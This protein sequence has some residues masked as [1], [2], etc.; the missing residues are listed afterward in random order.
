M[1]IFDTS[2][3][4][5]LTGRAIGRSV[6][7]IAVLIAAIGGTAT[8][9]QSQVLSAAPAS[10]QAADLDLGQVLQEALAGQDAALSSQ[11]MTGIE[12]AVS[13]WGDEFLYALFKGST[14]LD[15][16]AAMGVPAPPSN[17][18]VETQAEL[19][20][21]LEMQRSDRTPVELTHIAIE[22]L[23]GMFPSDLYEIHGLLPPRDE[24]PALWAVLDAVDN[25]AR[26][27]V[28]REKMM[29]SR[30]RPY[31]LEP[32][33]R[34]E[35]PPPGHASYP[36]AHATEYAALAE[37]MSILNPECATSYRTLSDA[38]G[39]RREIAGVH[40]PSDTAAGIALGNRVARTLYDE[41]HLKPLIDALKAD[42]TAGKV[43][44]PTCG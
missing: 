26:F 1:Q 16:N 2:L 39:H 19:V 5:K 9:A 3:R 43:P 29:W 41:G 23:Q 37:I 15:P 7:L 6:P 44:K 14:F 8:T 34:T 30:A 11:E 42:A 13:S 32:A 25:E 36:S 31:A 40:Y 20:A 33:L 22:N 35:V 10:D 21:L 12:F 28:M 4:G 38:V 27:F 17:A 18:S 24:A